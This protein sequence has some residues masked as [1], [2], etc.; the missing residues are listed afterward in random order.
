MDVVS[1]RASQLYSSSVRLLASTFASSQSQQQQQ[2]IAFCTLLTVAL[3]VLL[4]SFKQSRLLIISTTSTTLYYSSLN[5]THC[6]KCLRSSV[7]RSKL[8]LRYYNYNNAASA[9]FKYL[10]LKRLGKSLAAALTQRSTYTNYLLKPL[11]RTFTTMRKQTNKLRVKNIINIK[12]VLKLN[13]G[14]KSR[15]V[16]GGS[17]QSLSAYCSACDQSA[18]N[19]NNG[20]LKA[21]GGPMATS[22]S[23][24]MFKPKLF[25]HEE[26]SEHGLHRSYT[27]PRINRSKVC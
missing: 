6:L 12:S 2:L 4:L 26:Q 1:F 9:S 27:E 25:V 10:K 18:I 17:T 3:S 15:R 21:N 24:P 19:A 23:Y 7:H 14:Q 11:N 20:E 5:V 13:N 16:G 22:Q 8:N